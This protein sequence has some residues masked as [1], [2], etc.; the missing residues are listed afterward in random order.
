MPPGQGRIRDEDIAAV[1]ER[2][3][4]ADL[5]GRHVTL[6]PAGSGSLKGLC[7][8]HDEKSPS[9]RVTPGPGYFHCLAGET[10]V[11]TEHG[12][13]PIRDLAG[14]TARIVTSDGSVTSWTEAPFRS[15][16]VQSLSKITLTRGGRTKTIH[17]TSGHRW[18]IRS[19][20]PGGSRLERITADLRPGHRLVSAHPAERI[21]KRGSVPSPFRIVRGFKASERRGWVVR[22]VEET[23]RVEEVYCAVVDGT[24]NFTLADNILTGN[25][26]GCGV[27]GDALSFVQQFEHLGFVEAVEYLADFA[28]Y[29]LTYEGGGPSA[30][31]RAATRSQRARLIDINKKSAAFFQ[32]SLNEPEASPA[33]A[34]L[35]ERGFDQ[36]AAVQF[37][38]GYAPQG[39][40]AL[41]T[42]L[43]AAGFADKDMVDS[44][45]ASEGR[46]GTPVDRFRGRLIFPIRDQSSEIIGFGAR[47]LY[48]SDDGPKYLNTPETILYKKSRVLYGLHDA[49]KDISRTQ[50]ATIVEGYTDVMAC[51]LAGVT[52]AVAT[53][54]TAF[55][56]DHLRVLQRLL[57]INA[58]LA[59]E[60]V[61]CFDGDAAGRKAALRAFE[62][63]EKFQ[64]RT[65]IAIAPA[66]LDPCDLRLAQGNEAV[67]ALV[68][69][70]SPLFTFAIRSILDNH[71][72][73]TPD[74]RT[75]AL[76]QAGPLV[77]RIK[78]PSLRREYALSLA[79][80][81]GV[82]EATILETLAASAPGT[83][84]PLPSSGRSGG[85][86]HDEETLRAERKVLAAVLRQP[87]SDLTLLE[88]LPVSAFTA[89]AHQAVWRQVVGEL[90]QSTAP[91]LVER[92]RGRL[93]GSGHEGTLIELAVSDVAGQSAE[94][95][96]CTMIEQILAYLRGEGQA[97]IDRMREPSLAASD[98]A[99]LSERLL[100]IN[101][102]KAE[103]EQQLRYLQL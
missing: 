74:G 36:A 35:A 93:A 70:R 63:D 10:E 77:A 54:G 25:C 101:R 52:T 31:E 88:L 95:T 57:T 47:L 34:F 17:A 65:S 32:R 56:E 41:V 51:H 85:T 64:A 28:N 81:S 46:R 87:P 102:S 100:A 21:K 20:S 22:S 99:V 72:L 37:E 7:P 19:N 39:W 58:E 3:D 4:I 53:C 79:R 12:N 44:G 16:G 82:N 14:G 67:L 50:R 30:A 33:R 2:V 13:V 96:A 94:M 86:Q 80:W 27:G 61:F 49:R 75:R 45:V 71:D 26:F 29:T 73:R 62:F 84:S 1:R 66:G 38:V 89:P 92:V 68:D 103:L 43:R 42:H 69:N 40:D 98:Q 48:D 15:F 90:T 23:D 24:H 55:G 97:V 91:G 83:P 8:F 78:S 11:I 76:A 5:I 59:G 60:V 6:K 9:F 18:F